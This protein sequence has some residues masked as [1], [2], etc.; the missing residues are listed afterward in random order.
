[1]MSIYT[2]K[3]STG[4]IKDMNHDILKFWQENCTRALERVAELL[5]ERDKLKK[6]LQLAREDKN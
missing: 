6:E 1:M 3:Q 2:T 5:K 4:D